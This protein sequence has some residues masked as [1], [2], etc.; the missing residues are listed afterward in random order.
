MSGNLKE[1]RE[2]P[3]TRIKTAQE[4]EEKRMSPTCVMQMQ[5]NLH[6]GCDAAKAPVEIGVNCTETRI[7]AHI[8]S[9]P[10]PPNERGSV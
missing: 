2:C 4:L 8:V 7:S 1:R 9:S 3:G 5:N 6:I 10:K